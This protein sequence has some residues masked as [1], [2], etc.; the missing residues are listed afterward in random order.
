[1]WDR[2]T[3]A[4]EVEGLGE[5][6]LTRLHG[7]DVRL[8]GT[9]RSDQID[10]FGHRVY[11]RHRDIALSVRIRMRRVVD[12][13]VRGL[14]LGDGGDLY[15]PPRAPP[16]PRPAAPPPPGGRERARGT[17]ARWPP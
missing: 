5:H 14:V 8:V 6:L 2:S 3:S 13:A 7:G 11:I 15:A 1:M 10:H 4:K 9:G 16:P 12:E 17:R